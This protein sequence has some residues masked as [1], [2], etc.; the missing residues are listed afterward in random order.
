MAHDTLR[1]SRIM[2]ASWDIQKRKLKTRSKALAMAWTIFNCEDITVHYLTRKLNRDKPVAR[3]I[4]QQFA[5][6]NHS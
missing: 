2:A 1:L 5:L 3:H 4:E 6:F